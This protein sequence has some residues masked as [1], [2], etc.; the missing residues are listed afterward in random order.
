VYISIAHDREGRIRIYS[1]QGPIYMNRPP[2][3]DGVK[4]F[5]QEDKVYC[6]APLTLSNVPTYLQLIMEAIMAWDDPL[7]VTCW[8][9]VKGLNSPATPRNAIGFNDA[10]REIWVLKYDKDGNKRFAEL[11]E[12]GGRSV[13]ATTFVVTLSKLFFTNLEATLEQQKAMTFEPLKK[14]VKNA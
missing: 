13:I 14:G 4:P 3:P 5:F 12:T 9:E 1:N 11:I 8:E 10:H 7:K 2:G 6:T